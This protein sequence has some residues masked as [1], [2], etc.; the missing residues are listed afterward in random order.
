M[1]ASLYGA[2]GSDRH[3]KFPAPVEIRL[4]RLSDACAVGVT[5]GV[6]GPV[7]LLIHDRRALPVRA[8]SFADCIAVLADDVADR[9]FDSIPSQFAW[10]IVVIMVATRPGARDA[11]ETALRLTGNLAIYAHLTA[12]FERPTTGAA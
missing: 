4:V 11:A 2:A 9:V 3:R 6:I 8:V 7:V 5:G 12:V 1:L 10:T